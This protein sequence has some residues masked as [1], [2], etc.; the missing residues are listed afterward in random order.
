MRYEGPRSPRRGHPATGTDAL[1]RGLGVV[2]IL[3][4]TA[5]LLAPRALARAL[6]IEGQA[7]LLRAY[8][9]REIGTGIGILA[10]DDPMPWMVGRLAGDA[11]DF[12]TLAAAAPGNRCKD[13][14][15]LAAAAVAAVTVVDAICVDRLG[16]QTR[17]PLPPLRSYRDRSGF[18]R[19]AVASRG[20][21]KDVEGSA[22][23]VT[24]GPLRPW[25]A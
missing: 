13:N 14:L 2:S 1:A 15:L 8:G 10:S 23:F 18:P 20:V 19:G 22:G 11:V 12:A 6:D 24:A 9:L 7:G 25:A 21:A 5:E 3:L 16:Q 17:I 4:G